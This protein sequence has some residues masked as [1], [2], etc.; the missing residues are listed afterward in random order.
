MSTTLLELQN[1]ES[2]FLSLAGG[3]LSLQS[4]AYQTEIAFPPHRHEEVSLVLCTG[5]MIESTQ[6][7]IREPMRFGDVVITNRRIVH[8]SHYLVESGFPSGVTIQLDVEA[9][10]FFQIFHKLFL[11]RLSNENWT[12]LA[13][14]IVSEIESRPLYWQT[15]ASAL[16]QDLVTRVLRSWPQ[17][18]VLGGQAHQGD[19]LSRQDFVETVVSLQRSPAAFPLATDEDFLRR[20]SNTT[21]LSLDEFASQLK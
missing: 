9:Q 19:L 8:S 5:G 7:G 4:F 12:S 15:R 10:Q 16:A 18:L 14:D 13:L 6:F 3:L 11:G 2:N 20:F 17:E 21:S 1:N